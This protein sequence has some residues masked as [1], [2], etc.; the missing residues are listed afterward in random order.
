MCPDLA[1]AKEPQVV[2]PPG[3]L[4]HGVSRSPTAVLGQSNLHIN[5]S[6]PFAEIVCS[7]IDFM[8][9][10]SPLNVAFFTV[11]SQLS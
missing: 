11:H 5:K 8:Q 6:I 4:R 10:H 3:A 2:E 7:F 1:H 9:T